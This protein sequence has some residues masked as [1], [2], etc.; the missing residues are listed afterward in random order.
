[1]SLKICYT[2]D[3]HGNKFFIERLFHF[4]KSNNIDTVIIGG[5]ILPVID[6]FDPAS[7]VQKIFI[8]NFLARYL[9]KFYK[10]SGKRKLFIIPGNNDLLFSMKYFDLLEGKGLLINLDRKSVKLENEFELIGYP[11]VPPTNFSFKDF[12]KKDKQEDKLKTQRLLAFVSEN[13]R[14]VRTDLEKHFKNR[15]SIE[16][17]LKNLVK[18]EDFKKAV[19]V[20]HSPPYGTGLDVLYNERN[21]GSKSIYDFIE[22]NQPLLTLHG[23]IHESY[24]MTGKYYTKIGNTI[25]VNP[26]KSRKHLHVVTIDLFNPEESIEFYKL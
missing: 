12:E 1:L 16:D 17:D 26:G 3:I 15:N 18:P 14:L 9:L 25:S 5:D 24:K 13:E 20:M 4:V 10:S 19:Y 11:F 8:L 7:Q 2:C 22:Q 6:E 23:H 21:V